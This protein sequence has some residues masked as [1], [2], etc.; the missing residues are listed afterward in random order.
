MATALVAA[1]VLTAK[2]FCGMTTQV[3]VNVR[4]YVVTTV[5]AA[6]PTDQDFCTQI[7]STFQLLYK[8]LLTSQA[9]FGGT[10]VQIIR[11][12]AAMAVTA[13]LAGGVGTGG[14]S[15][16]PPTVA[17]LIKLVSSVP[18]RIGR[19]R[20]YVPFPAEEQSSPTGN[21]DALYQAALAVL[22]AQLILPVVVV[23]GGGSVTLTPC[24]YN[25]PT[26]ATRNLAAFVV[27][28][29]WAS[30]RRRSFLRGGDALPF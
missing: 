23:A 20:I 19:G 13:V 17:G 10:S 6:G 25:R 1:Q 18:G 7:N 30:C 12:T 21:P 4:H 3:S 29:E 2:F 27:R 16:L 15:A 5:T 28:K 22:G 8:P 9:S 24:L 26:H 11:P 14:A